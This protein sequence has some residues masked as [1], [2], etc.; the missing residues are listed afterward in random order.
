MMKMRGNKFAGM[1]MVISLLLSVAQTNVYSLE[2]PI[3]FVNDE[4][5]LIQLAENCTLDTYSQGLKVIL[6]ADIQISDEKFKGIPTFGGEFNGRNYTISGVKLTRDGST[7]GFFR[8]IQTTGVVQNLKVEVNFQPT[9]T[10]N[11]IGG[12]AGENR[13]IIENCDVYGILSGKNHVGGIV[14]KNEETGQIIDCTFTGKLTGENF[15]GGIVGEN[16]GLIKN[17]KNKGAVNT[18]VTPSTLKLKDINFSEINSAEEIITST[19]S[20]GITGFNRG[21]MEGC[22]N[23][24]VVGYPHV[25][26]NVGGIAGRQDGYIGSSVNHGD[27]FGRKDVGG[28]V[29]QM[30][31]YQVIKSDEDFFKELEKELDSLQEAIDKTYDQVDR[32][33]EEVSSQLET[34]NRSIANV[35]DRMEILSNKTVDYA[36]ENIETINDTLDRIHN[37]VGDLERATE[38]MRDGAADFSAGLNDVNVGFITMS[39]SIESMN[40]GV[41]KISEGL[42]DISVA[43]NEIQEGANQ[44]QQGFDHLDA[45]ISNNESLDQAVEEINSG[46]EQINNGMKAITDAFMKMADIRVAEDPL[47]TDLEEIIE[48]TKDDLEAAKTSFNLATEEMSKALDHLQEEYEKD[49]EEISL[50]MTYF[51]QASSYFQAS[52]GWLNRGIKDFNESSTYF[53]NVSKMM[54]HSIDN[55][56]EATRKFENASNHMT[57]SINQINQT[58]DREAKLGAPQFSILGES[59]NAAK[60]ELFVSGDKLIVEVQ[61]LNEVTKSTVDAVTDDLRAINDQVVVIVDLIKRTYQNSMDEDREIY[62]DISDDELAKADAEKFKEMEPAFGYV[63]NCSNTG[64]INGDINVGGISGTLAIDYDFDPEGD[65]T[66]TESNVMNF[67]FQTKGVLAECENTGLVTAKKDYAGGIVGR[68]DLGSLFE[69]FNNS[70]VVS[71]DGNYVGGIAGGS[72]SMIRNSYSLSHLSGIDYIGGITGFG[73]EIV[74]CTALVSIDEAAEFIGMIAGDVEDGMF[75]EESMQAETSVGIEIEKLNTQPLVLNNKFVSEDWAGIDGISYSKKAEP[76][77]YEDLLGDENLP[78]TFRQLKLTFVANEMKV[79]Y[80]FAYE[81]SID[82]KDLP[83]IPEKSGYFGQWP[84]YEYDQ[85]MFPDT[86][87]VEYVPLVQ[88]LASEEEGKAAQILAEGSFT[89]GASLEMVADSETRMDLLTDM[90]K[91][92]QWYVAIKGNGIPNESYTFRYYSPDQKKSEL[93]AWKD[94]GW[95][96]LDTVL[97]GSYFVFQWPQEELVFTV[98]KEGLDPTIY[99]GAGSLAL[100]LALLIVIKA[101]K[102]RRLAKK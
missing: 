41:G 1:M 86:I 101:R 14:A 10:E 91:I 22:V 64:S 83:V 53:E 80:P 70:E 93:F 92:S 15:S 40:Q 102:K 34:V 2:Q 89:P 99:I 60:N 73:T 98:Y 72:Y 33:N 82:V 76:V 43:V 30:E 84:E 46:M 67:Q 28:I 57:V 100:L 17:C 55:F 90:E 71:S 16:H 13:G 49:S 7:F 97:D 24:G 3:Y 27:V 29:G 68:M 20:G 48:Q 11:R 63:L 85:L 4:E 74:G 81:G 21:I 52:L 44:M 32:S 62:D 54:G 69:C 31:P 58:L 19:N 45:A 94:N 18:T 9:G 23:E 78:E 66:S 26:Y 88:V 61:E 25:G 75:E 6:N 42:T 36:D 35:A 87:E 56:S 38:E 95:Q 79:E 39:M 51:R 65:L 5:D 47:N 59:V 12:I 77:A 8:Y 37:V 50:A 96:K